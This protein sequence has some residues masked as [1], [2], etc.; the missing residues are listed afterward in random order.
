MHEPTLPEQLP[1]LAILLEEHPVGIAYGVLSL[2]GR[3]A[4]L[5]ADID[6]ALGIDLDAADDVDVD[7]ICM[8]RAPPAWRAN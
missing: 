6:I 8:T 4:N 1:I 2:R 3:P 5:P 7:P